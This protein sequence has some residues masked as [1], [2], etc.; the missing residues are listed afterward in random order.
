MS[1]DMQSISRHIA[2]DTTPSSIFAAFLHIGFFDFLPER[3]TG[4]Y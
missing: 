1:F 3:I 4:C 2:V